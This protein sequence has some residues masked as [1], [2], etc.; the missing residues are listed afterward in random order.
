[1]SRRLP[2]YILIDSSESMIGEAIDAVQ[3][4]VELMISTLRRD[5]YALEMAA[6][7]II[8]F[9][10]KATVLTPLTELYQFKT[11]HIRLGAGTS[12]GAAFDL[13][14]ARIRL[15]VVKTTETRRGDYRPI[16]F[17][18]TDGVPTDDWNAAYDRFCAIKPR[19]AKIYA[20]GCGEDVDYALLEKISDVAYRIDAENAEELPSILKKVFV[21]ISAS[22]QSAS[23][24]VGGTNPEDQIDLP[25]NVERV[26]KG[27]Y[28]VKTRNGLAH[29]AFLHAVCAKTRK[30]S[31]L[32][33]KLDEELPLYTKADVFPLPE[34]FDESGTGAKTPNV[35]TDLLAATIPPCP[36]CGNGWIACSTCGS[37]YCE[38]G[39]M[40]SQT[41]CPV[42]GARAYVAG[43][44]VPG[45]D[46]GTSMG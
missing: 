4:G 5:P 7:S 8:S 24:S 27:E 2:V 23:Q 25:E 3:K 20:L 33:F 13:L 18:L 36:H 14:S 44:D 10:G 19:P 43:A 22:V 15:E 34:D 26:G 29:N 21:W 32:R 17:L 38:N 40:G 42:C 35:S 39:G 37:I 1:M 6:I 45:Y 28:K 41:A 11:P 12:L 16:V 30:K 46:V 9:N 31:L